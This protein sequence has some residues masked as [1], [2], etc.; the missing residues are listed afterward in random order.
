ACGL[1]RHVAA[2]TRARAAMKV[3]LAAA[4][5][6]SCLGCKAHERRDVALEMLDRMA[7][8]TKPRESAVSRIVTFRF[9]SQED[10]FN[11]DEFNSLINEYRKAVD[12]EKKEQAKR[13]L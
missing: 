12:R 10:R 9:L 7:P 6:L 4:V 8:I 11:S 13:N 2:C 5:L 1:G 3:A